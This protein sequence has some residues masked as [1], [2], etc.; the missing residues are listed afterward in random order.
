MSSFGRRTHKERVVLNV[1]DL[2]APAQNDMLVFLGLGAFHSGVE[3]H[4]VEWTFGS[5]GPGIFSHAPRAAPNVPLLRRLL[6]R[7]MR[8]LLRLRL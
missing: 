8:R 7:L 4:G 5:G 6:R 3:V 1:Y 2:S